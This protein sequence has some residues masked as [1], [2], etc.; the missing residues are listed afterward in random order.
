MAALA[1][2]HAVSVRL[3]NS[4]GLLTHPI[5]S[6][7]G[8]ATR[9]ALPGVWGRATPSFGMSHVRTPTR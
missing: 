5:G 9:R 6:A 8:K 1:R 3:V 7:N 4:G 2:S